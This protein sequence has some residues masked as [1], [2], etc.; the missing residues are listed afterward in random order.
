M[1][2]ASCLQVQWRIKVDA[3]GRLI[4]FRSQAKSALHLALVVA[5]EALTPFD[6]CFLKNVIA[7]ISVFITRIFDNYRQPVDGFR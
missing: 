2:F 6:T 7:R 3:H 5:L 1:D 4:P